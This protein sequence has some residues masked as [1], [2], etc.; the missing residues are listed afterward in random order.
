MSETPERS[1]S[2]LFVTEDDEDVAMASE[3]S[4]NG[5]DNDPVV[6]EIP[7]NLTNGPFPLHILQYLNKP[8]KT[9]HDAVLHP[10]VSQVRYKTKSALWELEVPVNTEVF[11]DRNRAEDGWDSVAHQTLKGVGVKNE[12]QYVGMMVEKELYLAP[13]EA[14]AQVRPFFKHIDLA[15]ARA[16]REDDNSNNTQQQPANA[17]ARKAQMVT[18]SV[19]SSSEANQPR[20]GGALL[21]H[22]VADEEAPE[23]L[24]W[25]EGTFPQF[26]QSVVSE[27]ARARL[28]PIGDS[29]D[30]LSKAM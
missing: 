16:K 21:A 13:V 4:E 11:Y 22:K 14:V 25:I 19:K 2:Q 20:L 24:E 27:E 5:A 26:Q 3:M 17:Q 23:Q 10:P 30:Y 8:R 6:T 28:Q 7:I 12:G 18:M 9:A 15:A 1:E 29:D